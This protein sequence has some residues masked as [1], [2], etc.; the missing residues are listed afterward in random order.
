M[1][2]IETKYGQITIEEPWRGTFGESTVVIRTASY[3]ECDQEATLTRE[4]F[5]RF[6]VHCQK[7]LANW[8][9]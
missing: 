5:V 1:N 8:K 3:P 4:Q 2:E 7:I 9:E 6:V